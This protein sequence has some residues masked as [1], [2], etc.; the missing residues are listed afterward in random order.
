MIAG[1]AAGIFDDLAEVAMIHAQPEGVPFHPDPHNH[2]SY[3]PLVAQHIALQET[4]RDTFA[5]TLQM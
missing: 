5:N 1:K 4:L 3:Q 2:S